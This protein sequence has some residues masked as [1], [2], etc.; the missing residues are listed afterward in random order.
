M[1][2][3]K[4]GLQFERRLVMVKNHVAIMY[5]TNLK[6]EIV[7]QQENSFQYI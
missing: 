2:L 3:K 1:Y 6:E 5:V 7:N 4:L